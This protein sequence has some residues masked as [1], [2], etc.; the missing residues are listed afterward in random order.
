MLGYWGRYRAGVRDRTEASPA[1]QL[2]LKNS[3]QLEELGVFA[4][5][6]PEDEEDDEELDDDDDDDD[7]ASLR[8]SV[9]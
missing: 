1:A 4:A 9:R 7:E 6:E 8:E 5:D 2:S 3:A